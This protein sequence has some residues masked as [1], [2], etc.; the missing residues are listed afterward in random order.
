MS[1]IENKPIE[2]TDYAEFEAIPEEKPIRTKRVMSE[3]QLENLA[4][5]RQKAKV[6]LTEKKK[7][8]TTL[9]QQEKKLRELKLKEKEDKIQAELNTIQNTVNI[10]GDIEDE[11]IIYKK[12]PRKKKP[13]KVV[14]YSS[15]SEDDEPEQEIVY[16]KKVRKPKPRGNFQSM[17]TMEEAD[18]K[19]EDAAI[20][21]K[22]NDELLRMRRQY[23][24]EQVFPK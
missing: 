2:S 5:A 20:E 11:P 7:R 9:K 10:E 22:Y 18:K 8:S 21:K 6:T 19:V 16:K 24:M 14:Y 23:M 1:D 4:K 13:A 12:K 15:S 17:P 3:K